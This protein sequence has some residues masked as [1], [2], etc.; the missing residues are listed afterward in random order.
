VAEWQ[1]QWTLFQKFLLKTFAKFIMRRNNI[2]N[3]KIV[4]A[5][6]ESRSMLEAARI[7]GIPMNTLK[8]KA[9]AFGCYKTNQG[10]AGSRK[11]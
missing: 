8:R 11:G 4:K 6:Q 1:T 10:G 5:C 7:L 3:E 9:I 2:E